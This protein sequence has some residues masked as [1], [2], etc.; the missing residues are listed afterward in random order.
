MDR[1]RAPGLLTVSEYEATPE[2]HAYRV[3]L[4]RGRLVRSPRPASLHGRLVVR[5]VRLLDEWAETGATA[6]C[7]RI[8]A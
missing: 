1:P 2:E 3:E 8:P 5:L 6:W 4:V 7:S